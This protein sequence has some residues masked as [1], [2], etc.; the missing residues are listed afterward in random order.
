MQRECPPS[1]KDGQRRRLREKLS[2]GVLA[3]IV[4]ISHIPAYLRIHNSMGR[5]R[6]AYQ[7]RSDESVPE[8][9]G[10]IVREEFKSAAGQLK[11]RNG[12]KR[13]EAI[14]Q[15]RKSIKK[16]RGVLRLVQPELGTCGLQLSI[17]EQPQVLA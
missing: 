4:F 5:D 8:G 3:Q 14:H 6:M 12:A 17:S 7:L 10:R 16:I 15:A 9:M 13:D 2:T 11:S 1:T